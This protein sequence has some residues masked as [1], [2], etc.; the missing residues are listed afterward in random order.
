[1]T[2]QPAHLSL[3]PVAQP[4][5]LPFH[6]GAL[7]TVGVDYLVDSSAATKI[8][9]REHPRLSAA[10][11][12]GRACLSVNY[13]LY[14]HRMAPLSYVDYASGVDQT[15]LLG[16]GRVHV[17]CDNA[18]AIDAGSKLFAEPKYPARFTATMPSL[19]GP[20]TA[21]WAIT[22]HASEFVDGAL[23]EPG[24]ELFTMTVR[25]DGLAGVAVNNAPVTGYGTTADGR[26]LAGPMNI[27]HPYQL[28]P[29]GAG[30]AERVG[31]AVADP[32]SPSGADLTAL[33]ADATAVGAWQYQSA[34]VAAH[35]RPYYLPSR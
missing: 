13:Q 33:L 21:T 30:D 31:I 6:Y 27:Y 17:L 12:D 19:N 23:G 15:K 35:N 24:A 34:P 26:L 25:L 3:P 18:I 8:L 11:F 14:E 2:G 32:V 5:L 20:D 29:L 22:C 16:I 10:E 1:M 9:T 28:F 7:H 4:Y